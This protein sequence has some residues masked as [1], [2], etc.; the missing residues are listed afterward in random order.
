MDAL[1]D[2]SPFQRRL[3]ELDAQMAEPSFYSN[4][5]RA[6]DVTREQQNLRKLVDDFKEHSHV[7]RELEEATALAREGAGAADLRELAAEE[8][9]GLESRAARLRETIL[10]A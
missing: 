4:Q 2:I 3:E 7:V 5:R 6:A 9:P 10:L 8:I 1:P